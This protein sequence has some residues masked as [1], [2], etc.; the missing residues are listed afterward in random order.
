MRRFLILVSASVLFLCAAFGAAAQSWYGP[1]GGMSFSTCRNNDFKRST[2][3]Q[4]HVGFTYKYSL[5]LGF[6]V[7]PSLIYQNKGAK[8][9]INSDFTIHTSYLELPVSLQWGPDLLVCRPFV[10]VTPFIGCA[11]GNRMWNNAG[12]SSRSMDYLK[13]FEYGLGVGIG[14]EI[15]RFQ[16]IGRYMWN[17]GPLTGAKG[18]MVTVGGVYDGLGKVFNKG[19]YR[20]FVLSVAFL[21][22]GKD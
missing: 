8:T 1:I 4:W 11:L 14:L 15:W 10:D 9:N 21:F 19:N 17:F 20:G 6:A 7:Q 22:G 16:V 3:T 18:G 5:P 13:R 2:M 12:E